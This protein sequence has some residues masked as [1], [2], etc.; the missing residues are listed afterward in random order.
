MLTPLL[1]THLIVCGTFD[2]G[3][4]PVHFPFL[5]RLLMLQGAPGSVSLPVGAMD[6][7]YPNPQ[8]VCFEPKG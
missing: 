1:K 2:Y 7:S 6:R 8:E 4:L 5:S 3:R